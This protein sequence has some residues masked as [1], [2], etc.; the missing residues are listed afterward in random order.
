M[1]GFVGYL[2]TQPH[3]NPP[4]LDAWS[5]V[6][7]HRG[8]NQ[9]GSATHG[10]FGVGTRRLSILDLSEAGAQPMQGERFL[11]G[12]NG[13]VY[14]HK[15]VRR[16]LAAEGVG[17]DQFRG[18]SDTETILRA[19]EHWGI[20]ATLPKLNGIY[21]LAIWDKQKCELTLARDPLGVKPLYVLQGSSGVHFAS[22]LKAMRP[23]AGHKMDREALALYLVFGFVPSPYT[24]LGDVRKLQ[25]GQVLRFSSP[26]AATQSSFIVPDAYNEPL[27]PA[28]TPA[29]QVRKAVEEACERQLL[30]DVPLGVALSGGI[31][32]TIVAAVAAQRG[33][34]VKSFSIRPAQLT[35]Q[36]QAQAAGDDAS[37][38]ARTARRLGFEHFELDV[39]PG[40]VLAEDGVM[41]MLDEPVNEPYVLAEILLSRAT[42]RAGV[43]VLL[44]GHAADELFLGYEGY[45]SVQKWHEHN[46]W[47]LL[48]PA[49]TLASRWP[50]FGPEQR[51]GYALAAQGWRKPLAEWYGLSTQAF[52]VGEASQMTGVPTAQVQRAVDHVL[53]TALEATGRLP[54]SGP[55]HPVETYARL[56]LMLNVTDH[57]N[58]RL[59]RASM[60]Q[61]V[62][63]R[64]P[65]EDLAVVNAAMRLPHGTLMQ[66]G[67][68][69]L[70][71]TAFH[72]L[73][74]AEIRDRPKQKFQAP[75]TQWMEQPLAEWSADNLTRAGGWL[76]LKPLSHLP[77]PRRAAARRW[78][79]ALLEAWRNELGLD[80]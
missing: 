1:C 35:A 30:S 67:L 70:L 20:E 63:A 32:S 18:N 48:G 47:P 3:L 44:T 77:S 11:M 5:R 6:I 27:D 16:E 72:D 73:L 40:D 80:V 52:S 12:Y 62:E 8:P 46:A 66:G 39:W 29:Q 37:L 31:D 76:D 21:A 45:E 79:V 33:T 68:K 50:L 19:L 51:G 38:A 2:L 59:D 69:G 65:F 55:L 13:E 7:A 26:T 64:V 60:S 71:K 25:P 23:Y 4:D 17:P 14:N 24:L 54:S 28:L 22:E 41:G 53:Q 61:S 75:V 56:D 78:S 36:V 34:G 15:G 42:S 49:L 10:S 74:P 57:Y 58:P 43:P 9:A